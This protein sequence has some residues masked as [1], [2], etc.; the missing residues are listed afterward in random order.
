MEAVDI[1]EAEL[2]EQRTEEDSK[3]E[4][5]EDI[6]IMAVVEAVSLVATATTIA[7]AMEIAITTNIMEAI[8]VVIVVKSRELEISKDSSTVPLLVKV[9]WPTIT[10]NNSNNNNTII[11]GQ[12]D[13]DSM[14]KCM[15]RQRD[16][17]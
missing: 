10:I 11:P 1:R 17:F 9:A 14:M 4:E 5:A 8:A 16:H 6:T 3:V 7:T 2:V 15:K 13:G 12:E